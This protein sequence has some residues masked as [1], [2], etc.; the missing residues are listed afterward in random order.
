MRILI[1]L[2]NHLIAE[3][4][5]QVLVTDGYEV[6]LR[7]GS[8]GKEIGS[9]D[10]LLVDAATLQEDFKS[11]YPGAKLLLIDSGLQMEKLCALLLSYPLKGVLSPRME[12]QLL[13]KALKAVESGHLWIDNESLK[14]ALHESGTF[15]K[16]G[17]I[18]GITGRERQ[19]IACVCQGLT[20]KEIA[21]RFGLSEHTIRSHLNNIFRKYNIK[22]RSKLLAVSLD[23][24]VPV[25][26]STLPT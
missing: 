10:V 16:T 24:Q 9:P 19:I 13:K 18:T 17:K 15:S 14:A 7:G 25:F 3:A 12:L 26:S 2:S 8:P 4:I 1:D 5:Y 6:T 21:R 20:N 23:H 11:D 22:S